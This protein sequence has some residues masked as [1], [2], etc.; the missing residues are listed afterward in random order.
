[1]NVSNFLITILQKE[2]TRSVISKIHSSPDI[3]YEK[4][5]LLLLIIDYITGT[6]NFVR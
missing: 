1:M 6:V 5:A 4:I 2:I 3:T